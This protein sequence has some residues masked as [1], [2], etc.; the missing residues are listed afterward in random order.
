MYS[1]LTNGLCAWL[2]PFCSA[3]TFDTVDPVC[4]EWPM[5]KWSDDSCI[6]Q[7]IIRVTSAGFIDSTCSLQQKACVTT[8]LRFNE[9]MPLSCIVGNVG[10][11]IF[12][13]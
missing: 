1:M 5:D 2:T 10:S 6:G 13:A 3:Y 8:V 7:N 12:G 4:T 9:K 11:S